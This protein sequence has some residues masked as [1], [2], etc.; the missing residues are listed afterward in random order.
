MS[1]GNRSG[2]NWMREKISIHV[3]RHALIH[4]TGLGQARQA[5]H[6]DI[7]IGQ[8]ADQTGS[9]PHLPGR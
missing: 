3:F 4:G 2:V 8:E 7:S 9:L 1:D 6:Q 5:F